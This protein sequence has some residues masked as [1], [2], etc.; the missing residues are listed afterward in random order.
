MEYQI[1]KMLRRSTAWSAVK[2]LG[3]GEDLRV[4]QFVRMWQF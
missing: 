4:S 1:R 3:G 2:G